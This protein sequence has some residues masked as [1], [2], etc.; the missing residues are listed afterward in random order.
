MIIESTKKV[1]KREAPFFYRYNI[2]YEYQDISQDRF[3]VLSALKK[4]YSCTLIAV[5]D[6]FQS[7]FGFTGSEIGLFTN[8]LTFF[9]DAK[10]LKITN[11]YRN[12]QELIDIAGSFVMKNTSQIQKQLS[13]PKHELDPI[14][15]VPYW[16]HPNKQLLCILKYIS[17]KRQHSYIL[18]L[19]RFYQDF[20]IEEYPYL[21]QE[22]NQIICPEYPNLKLEFLT[23]H[24]AKGLGADEVILLNCNRGIYG[25]PSKKKSDPILKSVE[26]IDFSYPDAEERRL[27]YVALTRTKNQVFLMYH[28]KKISKFVMEIK[29][30]RK[31]PLFNQYEM[32]K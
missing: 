18:L 17:K 28:P 21:K 23:V 31:L 14:I 9:S 3:L 25:F 7:I 30:Q 15:L 32:K 26:S 24:S 4:Q 8:F 29:K 19:G 6:D 10:Q 20:K 12:S 2:V 16:N 11:T 27:F 1:N 5:G 22:S 13:S